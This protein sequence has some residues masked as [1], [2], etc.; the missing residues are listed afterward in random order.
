MC[1]KCKI[2]LI[3]DKAERERCGNCETEQVM[4]EVGKAAK[5]VSKANVKKHKK[6]SKKGKKKRK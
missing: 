1:P 2:E 4:V 3:R 6:H 5:P